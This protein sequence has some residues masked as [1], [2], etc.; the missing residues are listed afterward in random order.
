MIQPAGPDDLTIAKPPMIEASALWKDFFLSGTNSKGDKMV[1]DRDEQRRTESHFEFMKTLDVPHD[2]VRAY[3]LLARGI[4][5]QLSR[6]YATWTEVCDGGRWKIG[7]EAY[8]PTS[9]L[10]R[11]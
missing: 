6:G 8:M 3:L 11:N 9:P 5:M 2:R 7:N 1:I 10:P 4:V